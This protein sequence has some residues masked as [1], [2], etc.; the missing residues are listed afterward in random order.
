[1]STGNEK[2]LKIE[3]DKSIKLRE[4]LFVKLL[5]GNKEFV[6]FVK[7]YSDAD[8]KSL[9][10]VIDQLKNIKISKSRSKTASIHKSKMPKNKTRTAAIKGGI[11]RAQLIHYIRLGLYFIYCAVIAFGLYQGSDMI[12]VG[13]NQVRSGTCYSWTNRLTSAFG[14]RHPFCDVWWNITDTLVRALSGFEPTAL[15]TVAV[16]TSTPVV[17]VYIQMRAINGLASAITDRILGAQQGNIQYPS[18]PILIPNTQVVD[19][20]RPTPAVLPRNSASASASMRPSF[21]EPI[22]SD[23]DS[24][25]DARTHPSR[26]N[27]TSRSRRTHSPSGGRRKRSSRSRSRRSRRV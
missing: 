25:P 27:N 21:I 8:Y 17:A 14:T 23:N 16:S 5:K 22:S 6:R 10:E 3:L 12:M 26:R 13:V 7:N 18:G 2:I 15:A 9:V 19:L 24:S 20:P 11:G 1:M 4:D